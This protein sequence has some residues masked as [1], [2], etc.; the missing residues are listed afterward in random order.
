MGLHV[1]AYSTARVLPVSPDRQYGD[2]GGLVKA[3][4]YAGFERSTR[5]LA[6]HDVPGNDE[7][8]IAVRDYDT[9]GATTLD[10]SSSY[11]NYGRFRE[12]LAGL[13][14]YVP[15]DAWDSPSVFRHRPFFELVHFADNEGSIGSEAAAD[16]AADFRGHSALSHEADPGW[17]SLF[18]Q[19]T[20]GLE[21]AARGGLIHFS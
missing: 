18:G 3:F 17:S 15:K 12:H 7:R 1:T 20:A 14:G 8:F 13:A 5:G 4:A 11:G 10:W 6:D 16:L 21:L 2:S 19:W 9:S